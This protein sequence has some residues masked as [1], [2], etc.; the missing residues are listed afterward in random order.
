M[1]C[2]EASSSQVCL[3]RL[4]IA[5]WQSLVKPNPCVVC[6]VQFGCNLL[7]CLQVI[8]DDNLEDVRDSQPSSSKAAN[9]SQLT[10]RGAELAA[11]AADDLAAGASLDMQARQPSE[12]T[13]KAG[14]VLDRIA[15][16]SSVLGRLPNKSSDSTHVPVAGDT[17]GMAES[18]GPINSGKP[19]S[20]SLLDA[21]MNADEDDCYAAPVPTPAAR[22]EQTQAAQVQGTGTGAIDRAAEQMLHNSVV[23]QPDAGQSQQQQLAQ[24]ELT[25]PPNVVAKAGGPK[26]MGSLRERMKA[27]GVIKS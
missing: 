17:A 22:P 24:A 25:S 19:S 16:L 14:S 20:V 26:P 6:H 11:A 1:L 10:S 2:Q 4:Q 3:L 7:C 21:I 27:L 23:T 15:G 8:E 13:A 9:Q 18:V 12:R 5:D